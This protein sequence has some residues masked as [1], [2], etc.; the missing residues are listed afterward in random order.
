MRTPLIG[1]M[2][3]GELST[4]HGAGFLGEAYHYRTM[5]RTRQDVG[6]GLAAERYQNVTFYGEAPS[7]EGSLLPPV[8]SS[9]LL[10]MV[11]YFVEACHVDK[12]NR[13]PWTPSPAVGFR[14]PPAWARFTFWI[15]NFEENAT[16]HRTASELA[17]L[18][19]FQAEGMQWAS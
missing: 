3:P 8:P 16:L 12:L 17:G 1:S 19:G 7:S 14:P 2:D 6:L 11:L 18:P 9:G 10:L 15:K 13:K 5:P 4:G